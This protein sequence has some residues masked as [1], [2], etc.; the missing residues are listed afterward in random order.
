MQFCFRAAEGEYPVSAL[1]IRHEEQ[2]DQAN[3]QEGCKA[4]E[5]RDEER[6]RRYFD[7]PALG[8]WIAREKL[9]DLWL[10]V[11]NI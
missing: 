2:E 8:W 3:N 9:G 5:Q 4:K 10:F 11:G 6:C 7:T 1:R